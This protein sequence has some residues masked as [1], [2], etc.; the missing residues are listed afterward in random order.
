MNKQLKKDFQDLTKDFR[1][2]T[3]SAS[4]YDPSEYLELLN[5]LK[6]EINTEIEVIESDI[7]NK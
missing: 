5:E 3:L 2:I 4:D 1:F 6:D 7:T